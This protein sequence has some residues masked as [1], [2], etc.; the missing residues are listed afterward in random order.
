MMLE[1]VL[2]TAEV[3]WLLLSGQMITDVRIYVVTN[4][5]LNIAPLDRYHLIGV[6]SSGYSKCHAAKGFPDLY[7]RVTSFDQWIRDTIK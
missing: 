6:V 5:C 4:C 2:E 3:L 7:T 1:H